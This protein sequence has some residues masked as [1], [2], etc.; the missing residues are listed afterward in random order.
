[1]NLNSVDQ[2]LMQNL[3]GA[4]PLH[5]N[6]TTAVI[7]APVHT[8]GTGLSDLTS[9][10]I[11]TALADHVYTVKITTAGGTD[12]FE[13]S[14]DGGAFGSSTAITGSAQA[15]AN[16]VTVTF[17]ATTGHTLNDVWTITVTA[18][19]VVTTASQL[20]FVIP[21]VVGSGATLDIYDGNSSAGTLLYSSGS[22]SWVAGVL[23][24]L[25]VL[26]QNSEGLYVSLYASST[27]PD[28]IVGYL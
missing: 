7:G 23:N 9:G 6:A 5:L 20:K 1:M 12:H 18:G 15:L 3:L 14:I 11:Y 26:L 21:N 2:L 16:G 27:Y 28:L 4:K 22:S 10:G 25:P 8:V 19:V 13:L 17:A 24:P